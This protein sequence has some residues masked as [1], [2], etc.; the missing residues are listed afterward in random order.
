MAIKALLHY[1][2]FVSL[3]LW[4]FSHVFTHVFDT[5]LLVSKNGSEN[6]FVSI[7]HYALGKNASL[8]RFCCVFACIFA[9][10]PYHNA[11]PTH[12]VMWAK[13]FIEKTNE[14]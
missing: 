2:C 7:F 13:E 3:V 10:K 5:N 14:K 9:H 11:T 6:V 8:V 1:I 12:S 4:I